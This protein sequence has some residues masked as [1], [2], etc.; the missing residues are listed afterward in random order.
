MPAPFCKCNTE[1]LAVGL[2]T[3]SQL[4]GAEDEPCCQYLE[5]ATIDHAMIAFRDAVGRPRLPARQ[6]RALE[7]G[8]H[9]L[10]HLG[11]LVAF[12]QRLDPRLVLVGR[13]DRNQIDVRTLRIF[14]KYRVLDGIQSRL[15]RI[16][17]V[18]CRRIDIVERARR[19]C[20]IDLDKLELFGIVDDI[21][22]LR[23][24]AD[25]ILQ[26]DDFLVAQQKQY[27]TAI[28]GIVRNRNRAAVRDIR[29]ALVLLRINPRSGN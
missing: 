11:R 18:D 28:G 17:G 2:R 27:P 26:L 25:P 21:N 29:P 1:C 9:E 23:L 15:C 6:Y 13:A 8:Q 10:P 7:L 12:H 16:V 22:D 5:I 19:L 20:G 4:A 24:E 14:A 3:W